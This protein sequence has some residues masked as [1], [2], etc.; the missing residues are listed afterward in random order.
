MNDSI[1]TDYKLVNQKLQGLN[2]FGL[3]SHRKHINLNQTV[4]LGIFNYFAIFFQLENNI[5]K[6]GKCQKRKQESKSC[7]LNSIFNTKKTFNQRSNQ[8][9]I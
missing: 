3:E 9:R 6:F 1:S 8:K 7:E 4:N 2:K 5:G